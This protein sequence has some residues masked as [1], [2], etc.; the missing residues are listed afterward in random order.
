M[1]RESDQRKWKPRLTVSF[2]NYRVA[3]ISQDKCRYCVPEP[4]D[5]LRLYQ[6]KER[7]KK[8]RASL[9]MRTQLFENSDSNSIGWQ[10]CR[11]HYRVIS[12]LKIAS[13]VT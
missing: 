1:D 4:D 3:N 5:S 6:S 9:L 13:Y 2:C 12:S 7:K 8:N 10:N 11:E